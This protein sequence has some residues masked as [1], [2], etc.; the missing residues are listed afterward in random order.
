MWVRTADA[1]PLAHDLKA[2]PDA[3]AICKG[4]E[5]CDMIAALQA[6]LLGLGHP[7]LLRQLILPLAHTV[8]SSSRRWAHGAVI[9]ATVVWRPLT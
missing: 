2:R 3:S 1:V 7:K 5:P 9:A 8:A 4:G 6:R